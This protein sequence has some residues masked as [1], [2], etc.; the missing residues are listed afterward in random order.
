M[1]DGSQ[2]FGAG[3]AGAGTANGGSDPGTFTDTA[4]G[5]GHASQYGPI[6]DVFGQP[7]PGKPGVV[8]DRKASNMQECSMPCAGDKSSTCGGSWTNQVRTRA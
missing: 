7:T 2:C 8:A 3:A 5:F 4:V 6:V 1:Q